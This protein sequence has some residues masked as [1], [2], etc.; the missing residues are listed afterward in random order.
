MKRKWLSPIVAGIVAVGIYGLTPSAAQEPEPQAQ[1]AQITG[2]APGDSNEC[3]FFGP[4][5]EH[6]IPRDRKLGFA[7]GR[8]TDQFASLTARP[9]A[10]PRIQSF[11]TA[12]SAIVPANLIDKYIFAALQSN[13]I[14][15]A[16]ITTDTEFI[17]RVTLDLTG[18]IPVPADVTA[19]VTNVDPNKRAEL[20]DQLL[21]K[22]EWVD[23]W[24]MFYG[25]LFKNTAATVQVT[26]R[27][28]GR[29]AFYK[30]IH[31]SLASGKPYNQMATELIAAEG[32][33]SFDPANGQ[34][35]YL[36]LGVVTGGPAQD[37]FDSQTANIADQFLGLAHMNCLLCHNGRGHLDSLS[38]WGGQTTRTQAWGMSA[39]LAHTWTRSLSTPPDPANPMAGKVNYWSLDQYKTDYA[40]NTTSGNRPARQ[41]IGT[42]KVI[43]PTYIFNGKAPG[44]GE[45]YRVAFAKN[46]TGDFQFARASVNYLWAY[47]FGAGLVDPPDQF[48]PLRQDPNNPP[49]APWTLQASNPQLL[50][51]LAQAFIDSG[52]DVKAMMRRIVNSDTYQLA[53]DYPGTYNAAWDQYF[54]RKNVRRLW[55]EEIH[56]SINIAI[57]TFPSYTVGGFTN[58]STV[59]GAN[60]PGFGKISFA[61]QAPD[62]VNMPDGGGA[63][64]Q[65]LDVFLR[66]NRDDQPRKKEGSILQA[67]DMMNDNFVES[68][69]HATGSGATASYVQNLLKYN[70]AAIINTLFL[71]ILSRTPTADEMTVCT[72]ELDNGGSTLRRQNTE[73]LVWTLFNKLDFLFNY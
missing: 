53:S 6:F 33:N 51:A 12:R 68:R 43:T 47:F 55:S 42:V 70:D 52:Y 65:F 62:V 57:N 3:P 61:M 32:D 36:A 34:V 13:G 72:A 11:G 9:T 41:P 27:P 48:D 14:T 40:L 56:D 23:K 21:A 1:S 30:W 37:I 63:V 73:D 69:I 20:V 46:V 67:L 10:Q 4:N 19:F 7:A 59:Y 60:S 29:N 35:N 66:G 64:S 39:F 28:E 44:T 18:R 15:P 71:D 8:L 5:R 24:T 17:R 25:D 50:N 22:P 38:L 16:N 49:P 26:I 54:A 2:V 58:P 31:D 45:D